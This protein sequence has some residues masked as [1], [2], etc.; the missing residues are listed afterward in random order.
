MHPF[1]LNSMSL[2]SWSSL[3]CSCVDDIE[4]S[5]TSW[6]ARYVTEALCSALYH[7]L[8]C[9]KILL[10]SE[11]LQGKEARDAQLRAAR[12]RGSSFSQVGGRPL[13]GVRSIQSQAIE[14]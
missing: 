5:L 4:V 2:A 3:Q 1:L 12:R 11:S 8:I 14:D 10:P 9:L 13:T 6:I 7:L